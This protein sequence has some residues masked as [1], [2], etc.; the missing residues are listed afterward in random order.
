MCRRKK[1]GKTLYKTVCT[2]LC[3]IILHPVQWIPGAPFM[4]QSDQC[5]CGRYSS[6]VGS[7]EYDS[8]WSFTSAPPCHHGMVQS[9]RDNFTSVLDFTLK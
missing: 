4:G 2:G 9:H 1:K 6:H 7:A 8:M 5:V 3:K